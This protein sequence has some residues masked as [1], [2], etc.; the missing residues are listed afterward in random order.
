MYKYINDS[1]N[2]PKK[3]KYNNID[4]PILISIHI[5]L[6]TSFTSNLFINFTGFLLNC[7][8]KLN[9]YIKIFFNFYS[10]FNI[11]N[12]KKSVNQ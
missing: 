3:L 11:F 2:T 1:T 12:L 4:L 9:F 7:F 10:I 5:S 8:I 6:F